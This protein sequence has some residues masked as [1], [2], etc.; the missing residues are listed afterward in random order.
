MENSFCDWIEIKMLFLWDSKIWSNWTLSLIFSVFLQ[1]KRSAC[2]CQ[3]VINSTIRIFINIFLIFILVIMQCIFK[4]S[5]WWFHF[6]FLAYDN[7]LWIGF[8]LFFFFSIGFWNC[9]RLIGYAKYMIVC[10][11]VS[12]SHQ[13]ACDSY[14]RVSVCDGGL[15][16]HFD[17]NLNCFVSSSLFISSRA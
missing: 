17:L 8:F 11:L 10:K 5:V 2:A 12:A 1:D 13:F 4:I 14:V 6:K 15:G 16:L 9:M 3:T 7:R